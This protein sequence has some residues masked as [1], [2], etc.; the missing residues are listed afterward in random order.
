MSTGSRFDI[1]GHYLFPGRPRAHESASLTPGPHA[2]F[3]EHSRDVVLDSPHGQHQGRGDLSVGQAFCQQT[4]YID[5]PGGQ[6]SR[7]IGGSG[8]FPLRYL[9]HVVSPSSWANLDGASRIAL[10]NH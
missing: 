3:A 2:E 7:M 6:P 5:L 8:W 1:G 9:V 4:E 10:T